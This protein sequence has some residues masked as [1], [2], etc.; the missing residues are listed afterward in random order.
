MHARTVLTGVAALALVLTGCSVPY[1]PSD[2]AAAPDDADQTACLTAGAWTLD[3]IRYAEDVA[4][5]DSLGSAPILDATASGSLSIRFTD[6][7]LFA[8]ASSA[9]TTERR[10]ENDGETVVARWTRDDQVSGEWD[11]FDNETL[12]FSRVV[13]LSESSSNEAIVD[14]QTTVSFFPEPPRFFL[15]DGGP[16]TVACTAGELVL[17]SDSVIA[18]HFVRG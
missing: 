1:L 14:N 13:Y 5:A 10:Y 12:V 9:F 4:T 11:W 8:G 6:D 7:F 2:P 15:S 17:D 3:L 16:W 18:W